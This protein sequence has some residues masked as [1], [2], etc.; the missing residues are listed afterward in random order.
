MTKIKF[1]AFGKV[2]IKDSKAEERD[3]DSLYM[4]R[5]H[6]IENNQEEKVKEVEADISNKL[7][8]HQRA[9]YE[10]K[11]KSLNEL[12]SNKGSQAALF[13]L[14]AKV[15]GDKKAKQE[16]VSMVDPESN[17]MLF[18]PEQIKEASTKYLT[19][20]LTNRKPR[21]GFEKVIKVKEIIHDIRMKEMIIYPM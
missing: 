21:E 10:E 11:L 15:V 19:E 7:L 17:E 5:K 16:A 3:L 8:A 1:K 12:K 4:K 6:L 13:K 14:K 20:L 18:E 2:S 9:A